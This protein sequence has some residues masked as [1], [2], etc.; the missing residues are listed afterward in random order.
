MSMIDRLRMI[1]NQERSTRQQ[2][3]QSVNEQ[4]ISNQLE[5][6]L[7]PTFVPTEE[8]STETNDSFLAGKTT[9]YPHSSNIRWVKFFPQSGELVIKFKRTGS[10]DSRAYCFSSNIGEAKAIKSAVS[11]GKW[12]RANVLG[13]PFKRV[14]DSYSS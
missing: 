8:D 14:T 5:K 6:L 12:F 13:R 7:D 11:K 1:Q 10:K 4:D 9:F 3:E 2:N